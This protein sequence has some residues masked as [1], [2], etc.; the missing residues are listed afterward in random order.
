MPEMGQFATFLP[1]ILALVFLYFFMI[2]PQKKREREVHEM[3]S[4]LRVGDEIL[5]VG[6]IKGKII[7]AG[8]DYITVET[9]GKTRIEFT[10]SAV[11]KLLTEEDKR[12]EVVEETTKEEADE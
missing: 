1:L 10:R 11:Y 6:G 12:A 3:R 4:G 9:T 7:K 8:V 2:R 5:T